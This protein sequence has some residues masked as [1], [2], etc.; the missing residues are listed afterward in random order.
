MPIPIQIDPFS[1]VISSAALLVAILQLCLV[2]E[3]RTRGEHRLRELIDSKGVDCQV[4]GKFSRDACYIL[5]QPTQADSH[6]RSIIQKLPYKLNMEA[7]HSEV[8]MYRGSPRFRKVCY[9]DWST[10]L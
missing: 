8:R 10:V 4:R 3:Q 2:W 9:A 5:N 7:V 6:P 1:V